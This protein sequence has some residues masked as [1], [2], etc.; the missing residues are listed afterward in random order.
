MGTSVRNAR[1]GE[2]VPIGASRKRTHASPIDKAKGYEIVWRQVSAVFE[3]A[4]PIQNASFVYFIGE[5]T[6]GPLKI[7]VS[8][9]PI[10]RLR[11]MQTGNSRRLRI[12]QILVGTL[13]TEKLLHEIWAS[14]AIYSARTEG[15]ADAL[16]GTEWF[17]A[18]AREHML[19]IIA[20]AAEKQV[21]HLGSTTG[22][23]AEQDLQRLVREA[24]GAHGMT[25]HR[26]DP[27]LLVGTLGVA[28]TR[29]SRL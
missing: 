19:P 9:D 14:Y 26:R 23:V 21:E 11:A 25:A 13:D 29:I 3:A 2:K 18:E 22:E 16:P 12:E 28:P 5:E 20:T 15:K 1:S 6:D 24:H 10:S 4:R 8:K 27:T 7:G 17:T